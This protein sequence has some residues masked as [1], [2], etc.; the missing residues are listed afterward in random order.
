MNQRT[1]NKTRVS[2]KAY[3]PILDGRVGHSPGST[4][5]GYQVWI[6]DANIVDRIANLGNGDNCLISPW[7][8]YV[9]DDNN[10]RLERLRCWESLRRYVQRLHP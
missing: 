9:L 10:Y 4:I 6:L 1:K 3:P 2:R 5:V 7:L 8:T